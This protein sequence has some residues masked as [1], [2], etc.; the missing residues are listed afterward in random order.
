MRN[1]YVSLAVGL[2][3]LLGLV[4]ATAAAQVTITDWRGESVTV[5]EGAAD[6]DGVR[7][8]YHTA[9]D[10]PLVIFVHSITGPWFDWRHQMVGLSEHYRVV[11]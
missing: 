9:G 3:A 4:P 6:S 2:V 11:A 5:E 7:I 1:R 10:G 8:V